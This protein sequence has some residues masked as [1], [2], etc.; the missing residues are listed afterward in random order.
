MY[1]ENPDSED[2]NKTINQIL[3]TFIS[4]RNKRKQDPLFSAIVDSGSNSSNVS[5]EHDRYL[6][7]Y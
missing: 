6:Y 2:I 4:E 1:S 7:G 3:E 5:E